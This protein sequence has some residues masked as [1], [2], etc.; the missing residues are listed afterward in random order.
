MLITGIVFLGWDVLFT[1]KGV[2]SFNPNYITGI[3]F[4]HLPLEE[5]LFFLT[6]PFAC[7]FIYACIRQYVM[8]QLSQ[9]AVR[10][11]TLFLILLSIILLAVF[12]NRLYTL[13]TFGLLLLLLP[14]LQ[15][16]R[17][18]QWLGRFYLAFLVSLLPFYLINGLLTGIPVVLYNN[19][20][21]MAI[22]VGTIP[23]ED[24]FYSMCLLL[25]NVGF[26]EY[27]RRRKTM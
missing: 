17:K 2:W 1:L 21:N 22:R 14:W 7:I 25:M 5:I 20:Q 24:H 6:V 19:A 16:V 9:V 27:F 15:F 23:Y 4:F 11:I 12:Y 10:A 18:A 13:V 3:T 8:W 26:Y